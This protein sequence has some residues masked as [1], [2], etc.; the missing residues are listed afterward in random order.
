M[1]PRQLS[2]QLM[3]M[4]H[5]IL[6]PSAV[7]ITGP[8]VHASQEGLLTRW[9]GCL[10]DNGFTYWQ[11][12]CRARAVILTGTAVLSLLLHRTIISRQFTLH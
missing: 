10:R 1:T 12:L 9:S 11:Q 6:C 3:A 8:H 4:D 2:Q 7:G 5:Q